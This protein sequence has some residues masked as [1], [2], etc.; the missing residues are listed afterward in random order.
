MSAH[1]ANNES[2]AS[3]IINTTDQSG[4]TIENVQAYKVEE[5]AKSE[6][7]PDTE[8]RAHIEY[9]RTRPPIPILYLLLN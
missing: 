5:L 8:D 7:L 3:A 9:Q 1:T 2:L 4:V 6:V